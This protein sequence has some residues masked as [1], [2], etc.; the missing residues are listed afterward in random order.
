MAGGSLFRELT[1]P[2]PQKQK[3]RS[4]NFSSP[5]FKKNP[6]MQ[7]EKAKSIVS[8]IRASKDEKRVAFLRLKSRIFN[9]NRKDDP[10]FS[11]KEADQALEEIR[12]EFGDKVAKEA[13]EAMETIFRGRHTINSRDLDLPFSSIGRKYGRHIGEGLTLIKNR[14]DQKTQLGRGAKYITEEKLEN[15]IEETEKRSGKYPA[16][17]LEEGF[18]VAEEEKEGGGASVPFHERHRPE[19]L[20]NTLGK[21]VANRFGWGRRSNNDNK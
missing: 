5:Y 4:G 14:Y 18:M 3:K 21:A 13:G 12:E 20:G 11:M 8:G 10:L 7:M 16:Q 17:A 15:V 19:S 1:K 6:F 2:G 9:P